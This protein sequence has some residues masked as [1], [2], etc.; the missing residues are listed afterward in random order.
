MILI[1][2]FMKNA[3]AKARAFFVGAPL[4]GSHTMSLQK[5]TFNLQELK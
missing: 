3:L 5:H 2:V 1:I 4:A